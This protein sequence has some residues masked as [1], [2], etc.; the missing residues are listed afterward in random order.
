MKRSNSDLSLLLRKDIAK[1][2]ACIGFFSNYPIIQYYIENDSAIIFGKS[3]HLWAHISSSSADDLAKLLEEH[4]KKTKFY[5]SVEDWMIPHIQMYGKI[6]WIMTTNRYILNENIEILPPKERIMTLNYSLASY[7]Y[8][9]S[10]YKKYTSIKYIKDRLKKDISAGI[11]INDKL[12]AW[13]F[14]H[15]DGALG[16]LHV[17]KSQRKKGLASNILNFLIS[18]RIKV[19]KPVFV[20][21]VPEN[22]HAIKLVEKLGFYFDRRVSWIK[23]H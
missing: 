12:I 1:N 3:D 10:D 16:F 15:D 21:I 17:F 4:H 18:E 7:I 22:K 19:G 14:T 9:H 13:G 8:E 11:W 6:D 20:N 23:I 2:I 5:F